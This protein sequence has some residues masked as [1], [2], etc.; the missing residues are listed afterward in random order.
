VHP[1]ELL[2]GVTMHGATTLR[3]VGDGEEDGN[4]GGDGGHGDGR[5]SRSDG[6]WCPQRVPEDVRRQLNETARQKLRRPAGVELRFVG[7]G[8][9]TIERPATVERLADARDDALD[10][11]LAGFA[12]DVGRIVL[13]AYPGRVHVHSVEAVDARPPAAGE[14]PDR[15]LVAYGTSIT[16]GNAASAD[17]LSYAA[18]T[19]RRLGTDLVNLGCGGSAFCEAAMADH[20][21]GRD[22]WDVAV[23]E[24]SVNMVDRFD[25]A[26]FRERAG[27]MLDAVAGA[28]H[29][30][31]VIAVSLLPHY[32]D[33]PGGDP[34]AGAE[35]DRFRAAL[36]ELVEASP[37]PHLSA[38]RGPEL[39]DVAGLSADLLHPGDAGMGTIAERLAPRVAARL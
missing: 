38:V 32:R 13:G 8:P 16:Q 29:D 5:E 35:A 6:P 14:L 4:G 17:H 33:L 25:V 39:L 31:P 1:T 2:D 30:R 21:A 10:A 20:V 37:H 34:G 18:A 7:R 26:T 19:A 11:D 27:A 24:L 12:P 28:S 9:V 3:P 15:T 22:D 36:A 23:L